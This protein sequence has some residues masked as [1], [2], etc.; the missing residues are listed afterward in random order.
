M[1]SILLAIAIIF[2]V[3]GSLSYLLSTSYCITNGQIII[4]SG[5]AKTNIAISEIKHIFI[6]NQYSQPEEKDETCIYLSMSYYNVTDRIVIKMN[7][8]KTYFIALN[9]IQKFIEDVKKNGIE[10]K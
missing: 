3:V 7:N 2:V 9:N 4:R 1:N 5:F 6:S 10:L 8:N